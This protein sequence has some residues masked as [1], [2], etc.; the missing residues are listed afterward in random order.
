M[1]SS[2]SRC[3]APAVT[4]DIR[5][6]ILGSLPGEA[7]LAKQ[8]YYGH[9]RNHFWRLTSAVTGVDLLSLD[10][11]VRLTQLNRNGIGLWDVVAR[12]VRPGSLDQ[13]LREI[14]PNGLSDFI[15]GLKKLEVIAFNGS[16]A[17]KIGRR[18]I[19]DSPIGGTALPML[20][21]LPSSSPANTMAYAR[22]AEIWMQLAPYIR[23]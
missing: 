10:Y 11:E 12:A 6:L 18:Q 23:V 8:Q 21:D 7:S 2:A 4:P 19:A 3:F 13:H 15:A 1:T 5:V 16:S 20:R 9:P 22:K 14:V 17:S